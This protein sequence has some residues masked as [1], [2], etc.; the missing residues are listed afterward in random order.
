LICLGQGEPT[1]IFESSGLGSALSSALAREEVSAHTRVCSYDRM[2][3]GWSDPGPSVISAGLLADDLERLTVRAELHPPFILVA[4]SIGG[5]TVELFARRH[6][7]QIAGLVF[8][9]A[10]NSV[11]VERFAG[12]VTRAQ[13]E[14]ACLVKTAARFGALRLLDPL[15]LRKQPPDASAQAIARLYRVEPMATLCAMARGL[16]TTVLELSTAPPLAPDVPLIVL[17]HEKS[18]GFFPPGMAAQDQM[19]EREWLGLQQ[20]FAQH[21]RRGTWRIVP[22]SSHL[23]GNSQPHAVATAILEM[24]TVVQ[25]PKR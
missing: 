19:V 25:Q 10:G 6:P 15:R 21:S 7:D 17:V 9:D 18:D 3:M 13:I 2:G 8:V 22:G 24:L 12:Q 14:S 11:V 5:L 1:V 16:R 23:I 20:H 4:S